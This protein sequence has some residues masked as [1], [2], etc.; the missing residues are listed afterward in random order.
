MKIIKANAEYTGGGIYR[1]T[2][3]TDKGT[4][5]VGNSEWEVIYEVNADPDETEDS[6]YSEWYDEHQTAEHEDD[7]AELLSQMLGWILEHKPNGN[8]CDAEIER[9][10]PEK[11]VTIT[12]KEYKELLALKDK[13]VTRGEFMDAYKAAIRLMDICEDSPVYGNDVTVHWNGIYCN[14]SD[15]AVA[16]N[17]IILGVESVIDEDGDE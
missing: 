16:Y 3:K 10:L 8:Y 17:N 14:C 1:Y 9:E 2:A 13:K 6:W 4:W 7:Y 15:G 11:T 5:L 12:E